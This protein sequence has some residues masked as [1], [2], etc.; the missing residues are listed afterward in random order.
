MKHKVSDIALVAFGVITF[1]ISWDKFDQVI[2]VIGQVP[3]SN[4]INYFAIGG[5][6]LFYFIVATITLVFGILLFRGKGWKLRILRSAFFALWILWFVL[7]I[8]I[9]ECDFYKINHSFWESRQGH[10]H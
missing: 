8:P 3:D 9:Y 1:F 7:E 5:Q 4:Q 2:E 6:G 10:F